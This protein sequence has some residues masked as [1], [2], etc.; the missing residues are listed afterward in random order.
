MFPN[1][2]RVEAST[3]E[4]GEACLNLYTTQLP[5]TVFA[6]AKGYHGGL[7]TNWIPGQRTLAFNMESF[8]QGGSTI[9]SD[10][11]G[12]LPGLKGRLSL[13][14]DEHER[15]YLHAPTL[16]VNEG[17]QQ[18]AR[19]VPGKKLLLEDSDGNR[20]DSKLIFMQNRSSLIEW[21]QLTR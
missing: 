3:D 10:N 2:T 16:T 14:Q 17:M 20:I 21:F 9:L 6:A 4:T 1:H 15:M 18:P 13:S 12:T 11:T 19:V 8:S 5:M 7:E